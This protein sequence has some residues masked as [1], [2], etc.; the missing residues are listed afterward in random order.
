[1]TASN[2]D[3]GTGADRSG[4]ADLRRRALSSLTGRDIAGAGRAL[5]CTAAPLH[6]WGDR[7]GVPQ[8]TGVRGARQ[9]FQG[10]GE[11]GEG[12]RVSFEVLFHLH[13][14]VVPDMYV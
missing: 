7:D 4:S 2:A 12:K 9:G 11:G 13:L 6:F 8:P 3:D 10:K 5:S 1:M 14:S